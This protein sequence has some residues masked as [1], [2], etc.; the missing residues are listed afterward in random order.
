VTHIRH[1]TCIIRFLNT[2][3]L[4]FFFS[5]LACKRHLLHLQNP[6]F[7]FFFFCA[8]YA[9]IVFLSV[10]H[11]RRL[12]SGGFPSSQIRSSV[13]LTGLQRILMEGSVAGRTTAEKMRRMVVMMEGAVRT[14]VVV[15]DEDGGG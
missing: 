4:Y 5:P 6:F 3:F 14:T 12:R 11:V 10:S 7:S 13:S 9:S 8:S 15:T 2:F 1:H